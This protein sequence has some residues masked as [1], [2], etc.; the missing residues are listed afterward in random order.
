MHF[1]PL[2][3]P[4]AFCFFSLFVAGPLR[5][6]KKKSFFMLIDKQRENKLWVL[7]RMKEQNMTLIQKQPLLRDVPQRGGEV[8]F[9]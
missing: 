8:S 3:L 9:H 6:R 4:G 7:K 1:P 2:K 5:A